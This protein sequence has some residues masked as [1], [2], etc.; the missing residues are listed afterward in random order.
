MENLYTFL[1]ILVFLSPR[2]VFYFRLVYFVG[3]WCIFLPFGML[4][5]EKSGNHGAGYVPKVENRVAELQ[6]VA[7][8]TQD[9]ELILSLKVISK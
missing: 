9:V 1:A 7:Q 8:I 3:I 4:E 6:T 5:Q 2:G